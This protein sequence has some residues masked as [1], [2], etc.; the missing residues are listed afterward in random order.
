MYTVNC[1]TVSEDWFTLRLLMIILIADHHLWIVLSYMQR[2]NVLEALICFINIYNVLLCRVNN[3]ML[4]VVFNLITWHVILV[5]LL[6]LFVK[7]QFNAVNVLRSLVKCRITCCR[8]GVLGT[9]VYVI[10]CFVVPHTK[11]WVTN[12][13][14]IWKID[15][16]SLVAIRKHVALRWVLKQVVHHEN[17]IF[18]FRCSCTDD[19]SFLL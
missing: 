19:I 17:L 12:L 1:G 14:V 15:V 2:L 8:T 4:N 3:E 7:A 16:S 9:P 5:I 13:I 10:V 6:I 11:A 18:W